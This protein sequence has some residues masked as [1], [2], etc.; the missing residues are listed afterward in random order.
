MWTF[1][2]Y[3]LWLAEGRG[4]AVPVGL[5]LRLAQ[6]P[7]CLMHTLQGAQW[8]GRAGSRGGWHLHMNKIIITVCCQAKYNLWW[9]FPGF[10]TYSV[11]RC[12]LLL[13]SSG[14]YSG[15][16]HYERSV[17]RRNRFT[18]KVLWLQNDVSYGGILLCLLREPIIAKRR[19]SASWSVIS[20]C[21]SFK[22]HGSLLFP[23][24]DSLLHRQ[25]KWP[26]YGGS[27]LDGEFQAPRNTLIGF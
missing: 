17:L 19:F 20:K 23:G 12:G 13:P 1:V 8:V 10:S 21:P 15:V 24:T 3:S 22:K 26:H 16:S 27:L 25:W 9:S 11:F 14:E 6:Y 4:R 2:D 5:C 7:R 18:L